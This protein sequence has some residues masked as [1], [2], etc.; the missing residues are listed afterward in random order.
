MRLNND[1]TPQQL[2]T[3]AADSEHRD[4]DV[5]DELVRDQARRFR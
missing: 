3:I 2:W 1:L 5:L 4:R